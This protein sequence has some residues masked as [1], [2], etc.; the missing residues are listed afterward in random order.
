MQPPTISKVGVPT[1]NIHSQ[2]SSRLKN[3]QKASY[4]GYFAGHLRTQ[5]DRK[6]PKCNVLHQAQS[7]TGISYAFLSLNLAAISR[8][9]ERRAKHI[10]HTQLGWLPEPVFANVDPILINQPVYS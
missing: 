6:W 2:I 3:V 8:A 10:D 7:P 5:N 1:T 4:R 9:L